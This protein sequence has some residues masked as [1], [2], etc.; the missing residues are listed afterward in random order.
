MAIDKAALT[1]EM[2]KVKTEVEAHL[3]SEK[4]AIKE[5]NRG[6]RGDKGVAG[7]QGP[8]GRPGPDG[9][10]GP[11]GDA[12]STGPMGTSGTNATQY[13]QVAVD[14]AASEIT[15]ENKEVPDGVGIKLTTPKFK[16]K[17]AVEPVKCPHVVPMNIEPVQML[18]NSIN[19]ANNLHLGLADVNIREPQVITTEPV[20]VTIDECTHTINR[21][22]SVQIDVLTDEVQDDFVTFKYERISLTKLFSA[23]NP[24]IREVDIKES[25]SVA[26]ATVVA[27]ILRK[28]KLMA[29]EAD[30]SYTITDNQIVLTA[31][32]TNLA[33]IDAA[34]ITVERSLLSRVMVTDL[35]GF[36]ITK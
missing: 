28:Y 20:E 14:D 7:Y 18:L 27:E 9:N 13:I 21:N 34:T 33:Y 24:I 31:K 15:V 8:S 19:I 17:G 22:T 3:T 2:G 30:F 26:I 12:G 5:A 25:G 23:C 29:K 1:T 36:E 4:A 10:V 16:I 6:V 11:K 35:N 32:A